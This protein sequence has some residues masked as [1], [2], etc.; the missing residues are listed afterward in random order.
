M[1]VLM[2]SELWP[3]LIMSASESGVSYQFH[4][5][6]WEQKHKTLLMKVCGVRVVY[7]ILWLILNGET[8]E[9]LQIN[10]PITEK[11]FR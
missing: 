10:Y 7:I 8:L 5:L 6:S 2:E 1:I 9:W 3:N 4:F 11:V